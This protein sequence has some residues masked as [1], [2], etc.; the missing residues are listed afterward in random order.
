[1]GLPLALITGKNFHSQTM[2]LNGK[3][4]K[5]RRNIAIVGLD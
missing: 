5:Q 1:M 3:N 2:R 4:S